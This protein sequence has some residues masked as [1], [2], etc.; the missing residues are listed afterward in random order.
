MGV[1]RYTNRVSLCMGHKVSIQGIGRRF[2]SRIHE[3]R[4]EHPVSCLKSFNI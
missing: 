4:V 3:P 1:I 2:G